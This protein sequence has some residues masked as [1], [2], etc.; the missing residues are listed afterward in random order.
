M[1]S[2]TTLEEMKHKWWQMGSQDCSDVDDRDGLSLHTLGGVFLLA[3]VGVLSGLFCAFWSCAGSG[4]LTVVLR[5]PEARPRTTL[6][7]TQHRSKN[8]P[9][10]STMSPPYVGRIVM[11][12]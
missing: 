2:K 4:W 11:K 7:Q 5:K 10:V 6:G 8:L 9:R 3:A 12:S 1:Q